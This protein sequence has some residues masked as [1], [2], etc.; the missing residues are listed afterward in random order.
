[1]HKR[2][3]QTELAKHKVDGDQGYENSGFFERL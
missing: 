2:K 3:L 1:M